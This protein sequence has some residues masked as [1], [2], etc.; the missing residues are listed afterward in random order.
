MTI[1][2]RSLAVV[3][4]AGLGSAQVTERVSVGTGGAQADGGGYLSSPGG[5]LV[6]ADGRFVVFTSPA[7]NLVPGDTNARWD[8]FV[9][10]RLNGKTERE[11]V[12]S[13][14]AQANGSSGIDG[15]AISPDGRYVAFESRANN[16]IHGGTNGAG[17]IYLR[18]RVMGTTELMSISTGGAQANDNCFHLALSPDGRYVGLESEAT[19]LV[20]GDTNGQDDLFIHDRLSG[21]TER[22]SVD[23][24]GMQSNGGSYD[25]SISAN[26]R[27]V[28]FDSDATNLVP[29]DTNHRADVFL[30]DRLSGTT[31][32]VSL[33]ST[34]QQGLG[35]SASPSISSNGRYI[36]FTSEAA[37]LVP[38]DTNGTRDVFIR[39][40]HASTTERV[41]VAT[42]GGQGNHG[43]QDGSISIDARFIAFSSGSTNLIPG[44]DHGGDIFVRDRLN[45]TTE[46]VSVTTGGS[47][48]STGG[49]GIPSISEDGRY[50]VFT[51]DA[52]DLVPGD[53]NGYF[54]V[55]LHDRH[56][57]G[58]TSLCDP[59][60]DG[61][62]A[63]PCS[64]SPSG[65]D[66][67]CD[68]SS[69]T[70]GAALSAAGAAYLAIATALSLL[71]QGDA[72]SSSGAVYGQGVRCAGGSLVRLFAK[73][74][75]GGSVYVPDFGAGDPAI[76]ALSASKGDVI[77]P[78]HSRWYLVYYRDPSVLGGCPLSSTFNATQ[79]GRV[80]WWP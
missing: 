48:T 69:A 25:L 29:G 53:T 30:R 65:P 80:T 37:N 18:D 59:G 20:P 41:S 46:R 75:I 67:G 61:V 3:V 60:T 74:A 52:V 28:A 63:C 66:R 36:V 49:S 14:G 38:N 35:N 26:G 51:S 9:R 68:N 71:L 10:D 11:S 72:P 45:G 76:S 56:S 4:M 79:T 19:N 62:I 50:V 21:T 31:E 34:G 6:S 12:D 64:N 24:G 17:Q 40:R 2:G 13:N 23:S 8:V 70:G 7:T 58:F 57:S 44:D 1:V 78:G 39:D 15:I 32:R 27:Y 5:G 54:D 47:T 73:H 16:L 42:G 77:Q 43:G 22:V 33:S 55:F